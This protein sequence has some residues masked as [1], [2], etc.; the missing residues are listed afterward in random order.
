MGSNGLVGGDIHPG[1]T[2][3]Q[4]LSWCELLQAEYVKEDKE[5]VANW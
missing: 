2:W 4:D 1:K 5:W 3:P